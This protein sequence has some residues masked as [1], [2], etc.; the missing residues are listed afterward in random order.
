MAERTL[1]TERGFILYEDELAG[2]AGADW[3]SAQHW[4]RQRRLR[5]GAG[6]GRGDT[7]M[8]TGTDGDWVLRHYRR[9]GWAAKLSTD[10]YAWTGLERSR[11]W[12]EWRLLYSLYRE[13]LP[14]P[15][16]LAAQVR[17]H[18]FLYRGDL[19]TRRIPDT[20]SLANRLQTSGIEGLP[21]SAIG[22]CLQRFHAAGVQHADLN[23]HNILLDDHE[24][25]FLIDFDKSLRRTPAAA[26][27]HANLR[28]LRRSLRKLAPSSV[29]QTNVWNKLLEGYR[30]G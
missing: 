12:R 19:I 28:R 7:W 20:R 3:F 25:V 14:V 4:A 17:R 5:G 22:A 1:V 23:A 2:H 24:R 13:G 21:W 30:G 16:P 27:Q 10:Y 11:P 29:I 15:Q 26:W 6:G 9:G 18:G 8:V